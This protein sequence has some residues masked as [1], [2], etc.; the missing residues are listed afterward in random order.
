MEVPA[1]P[2]CAAPMKLVPSNRGS[3][4][5]L[6]FW[7]CTEYRVT[8]CRGKREVEDDTL[9]PRPA[10]SSAQ[11][12]FDRRRNEHRRAMRL[13]LPGITAAMVILMVMTF[14]ALVGVNPFVSSGAVIIVGFA[15][16]VAIA[17]LPREA[18]HWR[19]GAEGERRV[20]HALDALRRRD[21]VILH[22]RR[23]PGGRSNID[24]VAIG[25][26]G[27]FVVES[28]YLSGDIEIS[29]DRLFIADR[30][31]QNI[32]DQVYGEAVATQI[33]LGEFLNRA[34]LTVVPILCIQGAR[35]PWLDKRVSGIRLFSA[36]E[37]KKIAEGPAVLTAEEVQELAALA[38]KRLRPMY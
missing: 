9:P 29:D 27:I 38:D 37:L 34:R 22:D 19:T 35:V 17:R 2:M 3:S 14:L 1:C 30:E 5:P 31:R 4:E 8:G 24:H 11:D 10:G 15:G 32:V 28:K 12:V 33:A 20:G 23:M 13:A 36:R 25:P 18:R 21:F 26:Q 6:H 16:I 7:G